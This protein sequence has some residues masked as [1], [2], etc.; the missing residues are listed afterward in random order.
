MIMKIIK[1]SDFVNET[2]RYLHGEF[3]NFYEIIMFLEDRYEYLKKMLDKYPERREDLKSIRY[4]L[5][6]KYKGKPQK[7]YVRFGPWIKLSKGN[8][9][10]WNG[11]MVPGQDKIVLSTRYFHD[12]RPWLSKISIMY[13]EL[14]HAIDPKSNPLGGKKSGE[15]SL[16][17]LQKAKNVGVSLKGMMRKKGLE[18]FVD[19][20]IANEIERDD[21]YAASP[22]EY[23]A[24]ISELCF[25]VEQYLINLEDEEQDRVTSAI[26]DRM[27]EGDIGWTEEFVGGGGYMERF[28]EKNPKFLKKLFSALYSS[29]EGIKDLKR[30]QFEI[31]SKIDL[32]PRERLKNSLTKEEW[33]GLLTQAES[34]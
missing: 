20:V 33:I 19:H 17:I 16:E 7:V 22:T 18:K 28:A 12:N 10:E 21:L 14:V 27:R 25:G 2:K 9:A 11:S 31:T 26:L 4:Y 5:E 23:D 29:L 3:S 6:F 30:T 8:V 15:L 24:W 13:H 32:G 34:V 1:L